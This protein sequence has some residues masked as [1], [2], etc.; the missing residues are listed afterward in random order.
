MKRLIPILLA[1]ILLQG[2]KEEPKKKPTKEV[3]TVDTSIVEQTP[4]KI[5]PIAHATLVLE[6]NDITIYIDPVGGA[7]VFKGQKQP[8]L[9]LIT[10][11][12]GDHLSVETEP[13]FLAAHYMYMEMR[14][15]LKSVFTMI[16]NKSVTCINYAFHLA[17]F[18]YNTHQVDYFGI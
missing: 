9:I 15:F 16:G 12:H 7:E 11:V 3:A 13:K 4:I 14:N 1:C 18:T 6:W 5:I 2:C 10:D 8:D 17:N